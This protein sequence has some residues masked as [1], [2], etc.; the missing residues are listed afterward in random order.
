MSMTTTE[1]RVV[2]YRGLELQAKRITRDEATGR[3][4]AQRMDV[5]V[6]FSEGEEQGELRV[7]LRFDD[8]CKNGRE[9]FA[10]TADRYGI[11]RRDEGGGCLHED[12]ARH[13]P[14]LAHLLDWHLV[15]TD[16]PMYYLENTLYQAG[17]RD[18]W[19]KAKGDPSRYVYGIRFKPSPI[20]TTLSQG[21]FE[22]LQG[23]PSRKDG[24]F[25]SLSYVEVRNASEPTVYEPR[26]TLRGYD[27]AWHECPF[28]SERQAREFVE[29]YAT[30]E[31]ELVRVPD[32]Y[33]QGKERD[34]EAARRSAIWPDA[35]DEVL[36]LPP[37]ELK[38]ALQARLPA[39][40]QAF[41]RD[42]L[43]LGFEWPKDA[44]NF[45]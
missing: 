31:H 12:I 34:L 6:P 19:G 36:C 23:I 10:I 33:A 37:E 18:H 16:G 39:L 32:G 1:K 22:F 9:T 27:V 24:R 26:Y 41:R 30:L 29:A 7:H 17:N 38:A 4:T 15:S 20:V 28:K 3:I 13:V 14:A 42:M 21:A 25:S 8:Q 5:T 44:P 2:S 11:V 35:S 45:G 40:M 43:E